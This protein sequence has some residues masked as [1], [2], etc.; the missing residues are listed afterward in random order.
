MGINNL[1]RAL[2]S[3]QIPRHL[4][5]YRNKR[6]AVDGYCWLHK[7]IYLLTNEIFENPHSTKYIK[8][9]NKRL[10]QLLH[11]EITPVIVFDGDKLPMKKI[12]EEERQ[13]HRSEVTIQ[14]L[15][16]R[17]NGLE[18]LAQSKRIEG[19]DINP[20]MA[21]E[22]I[23]ILKQRKIE[24]FVAPYE[25]DIQLC[26]LSKIG[27]VDCVITEDSDLLA[28]GC[29]RILYKLDADSG[30]GKEIEL[31]N[32]K[33][34]KSFDFSNFD[35]D[36]FLTFCILSGC[37]YFKM[38]GVGIKN[39]YNSVK[40]SNSYKKCLIKLNEK[41]YTDVVHFDELLN[42]FEKAF[43]T[44]RYQ[45]VYCPIEKK[46]KYFEDIY[47]TKYRFAKKYFDDLKF[48][49]NINIDE[50]L[51]K[52]IVYGEVDPI[53]YKP[54]EF[55]KKSWEEYLNFK[56]NENNN[57]NNG[58][59]KNN[60]VLIGKK[61]LLDH[62]EEKEFD[63]D[64]HLDIRNNEEENNNNNIT[65]NNNNNNN[66][67]NDN[68]NSF[69]LKEEN[70]NNNNDI[71]IN[72]EN[73][74]NNNNNNYI[75]I[76]NNIIINN[77]NNNNNNNIISLIDSQINNNTINNN[78]NSININNNNIN[79][80]NEV[81]EICSST[82]ALSK[83]SN[84]ENKKFINNNNININDNNNII[85]D[86][87]EDNESIIKFNEFDNFLESYENANKKIKNNT[88]NIKEL[89]IELKDNLVNIVNEIDLNE[90]D[91]LNN[92]ENKKIDFLNRYKYNP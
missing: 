54:F 7:S 34:C 77:N 17:R 63:L 81:I 22:F 90:N 88:E 42:K 27:Y 33:Q 45:I 89:K 84:K 67:N 73:N 82:S 36:K 38:K 75:N 1:L 50:N 85:I 24:F 14:S 37:D 86:Y 28:L 60:N 78:N 11:F 57:N 29:E 52:K 39:A 26:Y 5:Y 23:K 4:S 16:L 12:E 10:E 47:K 92:K 56:K 69:V 25:A 44:F 72:K 70:N 48:L 51:V 53:T 87:D 21:Y 64:I 80:I 91:F 40:T 13:R 66:N 76:N 49:G 6:I 15:N 9:L 19:I 58:F 20:K 35:S 43:L 79:N 65:N 18:K 59:N 41:N 74:N 68:N 2:E 30:I 31:K 8:Y 83:D 61:R 55:N 32:L 62:E 46:L 3:I 71:N